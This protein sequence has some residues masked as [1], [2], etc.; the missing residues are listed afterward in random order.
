MITAL[1]R[2]NV[3]MQESYPC[4]CLFWSSYLHVGRPQCEVVAQ[5][6]HNERAVLV[7]LLAQ[8]VQLSNSLIEGLHEETSRGPLFTLFQVEDSGESSQYRP[9]WRGGTRA[10]A[11]S[12]SRSRK[13]R[14]SAPVP[15]EWG[16]W[17]EGPRAQCPTDT[18][19]QRGR[20]LLSGR[21]PNNSNNTVNVNEIPESGSKSLFACPPARPCRRA[22]CAQRPPSGQLPS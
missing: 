7:G 22:E 12:R 15:G 18:G 3:N 4:P 21:Q 20:R 13:R 5:E 17:A 6:L 2:P 16:A 10:L 19:G 9:A 8:R 14:S 11:S 1:R